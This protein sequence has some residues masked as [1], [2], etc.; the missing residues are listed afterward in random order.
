MRRQ[1]VE[2]LGRWGRVSASGS[3][4]KAI[5]RG[6][7]DR[8]ISSYICCAD[9]L[10]YGSGGKDGPEDPRGEEAIPWQVSL[11]DRLEKWM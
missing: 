9:V 1:A 7:A 4:E 10:I 3:S 6:T 5:M 2:E 8:D 11:D